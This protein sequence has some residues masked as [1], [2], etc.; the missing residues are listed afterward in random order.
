MEALIIS[1]V[2]LWAA[3]LILAGIVLALMRQIGVLHER[4]APAGALVSDS[5]PRVGEH[6]PVMTLADWS[7]DTHRWRQERRRFAHPAPVRVA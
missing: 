2:L 5:G 1:N 4:V 3:V 7:G 6:A